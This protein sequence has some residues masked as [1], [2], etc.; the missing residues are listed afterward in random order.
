MQKHFG[1]C[2]VNF[3]REVIPKQEARVEF[4]RVKDAFFR[5]SGDGKDDD[6][7][8]LVTVGMPGCSV[9][10]FKER[11]RDGKRPLDEGF[12]DG[13]YGVMEKRSSQN[14]QIAVPV[15][16]ENLPGHIVFVD[17]NPGGFGPAGKASDAVPDFLPAQFDD[18]HLRARFAHALEQVPQNDFGLADAS[19]PR[20]G[21]KSENFHGLLLVF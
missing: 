15:F 5:K 17:A 20:A 19:R 7:R 18:L 9:L 8:R 13:V 4:Q 12:H 11:E 6:G 21:I 10:F 14:N 16:R 2:P 1:G 3:R